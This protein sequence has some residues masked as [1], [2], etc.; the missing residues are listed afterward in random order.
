VGLVVVRLRRLL[1]DPAPVEA[2]DQLAGLALGDRAPPERP[3]VAVNFVASADGRASFA[4][5]SAP[6]GGPADREL[7]HLLRSQ[8]DAVLV[9]AATAARERYGRLVRDPDRRAARERAGLAPDP[10]AL[11]VTRSGRIPFDIPLFADRDSSVC[12][13]SA[14]AVPAHP[15]AARVRIE[16]LEPYSLAAALRCARGELGV[17]SVVCE[18]GP[19]LLSSLLGEGLVDELFLTLSPRLVG[20]GDEPPITVGEALPRPTT[21]GLVWALER[22]GF[23]FLR[24]RRE[25]E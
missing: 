24:Y 7:F 2:A 12:C 18:G 8:A 25:P 11:L 21:L 1:P 17:R 19:R 14:V 10:L 3:F 13:F 20:G 16:P 22:D 9:G 5:R 23:L 4:G 15:V 6:L